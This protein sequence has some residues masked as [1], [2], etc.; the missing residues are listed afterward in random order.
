MKG[1][2]GK[3]LVKTNMLKKIERKEGKG[4]MGRRNRGEG[5]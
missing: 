2:K 1:R 5:E 3:R 4:K